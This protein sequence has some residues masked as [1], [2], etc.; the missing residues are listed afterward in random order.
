MVSRAFDA[1]SATMSWWSPFHV[2]AG[3]CAL[4]ARHGAWRIPQRISWIEYFLDQIIDNG[5]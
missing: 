1:R 2:N 3:G 4:P 5:F